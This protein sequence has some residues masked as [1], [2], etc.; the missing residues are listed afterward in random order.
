MFVVE[1]NQDRDIPMIS[2]GNSHIQQVNWEDPCLNNAAVYKEYQTYQTNSVYIHG[3][4]LC[5]DG[6]VIHIFYTPHT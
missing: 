4:I 6:L 5:L 2:A 3:A 1:E